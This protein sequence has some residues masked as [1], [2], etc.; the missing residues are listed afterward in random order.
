[1]FAR[2]RRVLSDFIHGPH[3]PWPPRATLIVRTRHNG[4]DL[5]GNWVPPIQNPSW[6]AR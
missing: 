4:H 1:M 3:D 5:N 6:T 2:L